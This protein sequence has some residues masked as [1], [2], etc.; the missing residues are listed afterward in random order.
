MNRV[1]RIRSFIPARSIRTRAVRSPLK[2]VKTT[3]GPVPQTQPESLKQLRS[4]RRNALKTNSS[5]PSFV[6]PAEQIRRELTAEFE[7]LGQEADENFIKGVIEQSKEDEKKLRESNGDL[8]ILDEKDDFLSLFDRVMDQCI[9]ELSQNVELQ[10]DAYQLDPNATLEDSVFKL[11]EDFDTIVQSSQSSLPLFVSILKTL[12][13]NSKKDPVPIELASKAFELSTQIYD[14]KHRNNVIFYSGNLIYSHAR[15]RAD[16][17]NESIY[18]ETLLEHRQFLKCENLFISRLN[19]PDVQ[20]QRFWLENGIKM[21]LRSFKVSKAEELAAKVLQEHKYLHPSVIVQFI[22]VFSRLEQYGQVLK[23]TNT[24]NT[25]RK[26]FG[27]G[28][29]VVKNIPP[30]DL[31]LVDDANVI[32]N[33][34]NQQDPITHD[35]LRKV[36]VSL[37]NAG[38]Y[39]LLFRVIETYASRYP[40]TLKLFKG[41]VGRS[42][43]GVAQELKE[44]TSKLSDPFIRDSLGKALE[45][46]LEFQKKN[47]KQAMI[48]DTLLRNIDIEGLRDGTSNNQEYLTEKDCNILIKKMLSSNRP[49]YQLVENFLKEMINSYKL[50]KEGKE[51]G[52]VPPINAHIYATLIKYLGKVTNR[53]IEKLELILGEIESLGVPMNAHCANQII[54]EYTGRRRF[55][56]AFA[57]MDQVLGS[58]FPKTDQLYETMLQSHRDF[59][60]FNHKYGLNKRPN[61]NQL[62]RIFVDFY[63]SGKGASFTKQAVSIINCF[64]YTSDFISSVGMLQLFG[65]LR[66]KLNARQVDLILKTLVKTLELYPHSVDLDTYV[67]KLKQFTT[68]NTKDLEWKEVATLI[69]DA[70]QFNPLLTE[71]LPAAYEKELSTFQQLLSLESLSIDEIRVDGFCI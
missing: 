52:F 6:K 41:V 58:S 65:S 33:Y 24:L 8:S 49:N 18:M 37:I 71:K 15:V 7:S 34:W 5:V 55:E 70:F 66:M 20:G 23:W 61:H 21:Y 44:L 67:G 69:L 29:G 36:A 14:P 59:V 53:S 22:D 12:S 50:E 47:A 40:T 30:L 68:S 42:K 62:R 28:A 46:N 3:E 9:L 60:T 51:L 38:Y 10:Q 54:L 57:F 19:Q 26:S 48:H 43:Y 11:A 27:K 25:T 13:I 17:I 16:P 64:I 4:R 63:N 56:R 31:G 2:S 32:I 1:Y 39:E 45:N 35:D